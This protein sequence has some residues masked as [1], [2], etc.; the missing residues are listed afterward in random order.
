MPFNLGKS[1]RIPVITSYSIHYTKLYDVY[2][3]DLAYEDMLKLLAGAE[4]DSAVLFV[5]WVRDWDGK[6]YDVGEVLDS[7]CRVSAAPVYGV[8]GMALGQGIV[9]GYP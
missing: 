4:K 2:T 8:V 7:V 5:R 3:G 1:G 6:L 9:G